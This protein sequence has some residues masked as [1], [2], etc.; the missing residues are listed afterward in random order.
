[1]GIPS[2]F[3]YILKNHNTIIIN[4]KFVK[5]DILFVD[6]N[7]LIY[8]SIYELENIENNNMVYEKV[9]EKII[10]LIKKINPTLKTYICFDGVPPFPKMQQQRQRRF[11]SVLINKV[12]NKPKNEWNRNQITPGTDFMNDLDDYL[13]GKFKYNKNIIFSG[14]N[15]PG[16]GEHKI[17][18][19]LK[20]KEDNFKMKN[21]IIYGLDADLIMLG[22]LLHI[23]FNNIYLYK[24]TKYFQYITNI[25]ENEE[26]FFNISKLSLEIDHILKNNHIAQSIC[27]YI[28]L[29]FLCGNDFMPHI[30]CINI[31]NNGIFILIEHYLQLNDCPLINITNMSINWNHFRI[32]IQ[33]LSINEEELIKEN[34]T[35]KIQLKKRVKTFNFED[36]LNNLPSM[37][38]EKE[39]YLLDNIDEYNRYILETNNTREICINYLKMLEWTWYYYNGKNINNTFYYSFNYGP[40]LND[41]KSYIPVT[42]IENI[43][44]HKDVE[45]IHPISQLYFVLPYENHKEII[46][47]EKQSIDI[48]KEIPQLKQQNFE[49]HYFMCKYFWESHLETNYIDIYRINS[50]MKE[51]K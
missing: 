7:S 36:K 35:W 51:Y 25:N 8:D 3:N 44:Q 46:P 32:F 12:L 34:L 16:E 21:I 29:C 10:I 40:L 9:Y 15:E 4:K 2:Y 45:S 27:D 50:L 18:H 22:M 1:M 49:V 30:P 26:Y 37:D 39:T 48:Y 33:N 11:K 28:F 31:R 17:C 41:L 20:S 5:S 38:I 19:F 24:E 6:A 47:K 14:S 23:Q 43:I 42:N 13:I